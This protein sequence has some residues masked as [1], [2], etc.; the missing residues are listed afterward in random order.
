[1]NSDPLIT[2][3]DQPG[4]ALNRLIALE[5]AAI[6]QNLP[7]KLGA[8]RCIGLA[9]DL[10]PCD[11]A[12]LWWSMANTDILRPVA[13]SDGCDDFT[14]QAPIP[15]QLWESLWQPGY[16]AVDAITELANAFP[17]ATTLLPD[18]LNA[19]TQSVYLLA[20]QAA[21]GRGVVIY[22]C[23]Q[24]QSWRPPDLW[25]GRSLGQSLLSLYHHHHQ[26]Q[27]RQDLAEQ[28]T[29][30]NQ[31]WA[32]L[33]Q[34]TQAWQESQHFIQS[35]VNAS[36]C[37]VYLYDRREDRVIYS[38][39]QIQAHLGYGEADIAQ[40]RGP[41]LQA[42]T[43]GEDLDRVQQQRQD[44]WHQASSQTLQVEYRVQAKDGRWRWLLVREARFTPEGR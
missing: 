7:W 19:Q 20:L 22:E 32:E 27:L 42:V 4:L 28:A 2:D 31:Y 14:H 15:L 21:D 18:L 23:Q 33:A 24:R 26:Q 43:H 25:A 39:Q 8:T 12:S 6:T 38:N 1:M 11:R 17:K 10:L 13:S 40:L 3:T 41:F 35:I 29:T 16:V 36:T 37:I 5:Q 44:W 30:L 34:T 9:P